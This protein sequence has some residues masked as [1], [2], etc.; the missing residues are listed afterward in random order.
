VAEHAWN[1]TPDGPATSASTELITAAWSGTL[2]ALE[3]WPYTETSGVVASGTSQWTRITATATSLATRLAREAPSTPNHGLIRAWAAAVS[4]IV[5][6]GRSTPPGGVV[7][8]S[9]GGV[10]GSF[11]GPTLFQFT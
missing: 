10:V 11:T 8:P 9:G 5:R 2:V 3:S 1:A 4:A 7:V 6:A